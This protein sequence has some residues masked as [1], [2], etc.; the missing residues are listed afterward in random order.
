M[1]KNN[2]PT[3]KMGQE[4]KNWHECLIFKTTNKLKKRPVCFVFNYKIKNDNM[5]NFS[6]KYLKHILFEFIYENITLHMKS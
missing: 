6:R 3:G 5:K 1:N 2:L 4:K